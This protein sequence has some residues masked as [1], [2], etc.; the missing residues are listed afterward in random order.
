M[1]DMMEGLAALA[2]QQAATEGWFPARYSHRHPSRK[3]VVFKLVS[4]G[5]LDMHGL[6]AWAKDDGYPPIIKR[7]HRAA[8]QI[9]QNEIRVNGSVY[10]FE[11]T[12]L[13]MKP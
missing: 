10:H 1:D 12:A 13:R 11:A 8:V 4:D 6:F 5:M 9:R 3:L 2:G 7:G